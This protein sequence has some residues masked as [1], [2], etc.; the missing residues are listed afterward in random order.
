VSPLNVREEMLD[1]SVMKY[2]IPIVCYLRLA[3]SA[4]R[5]TSKP[6]ILRRVPI[7]KHEDQ[8]P[9]HDS[10]AIPSLALTQ[11]SQARS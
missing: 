5:A 2:N 6:Q 11:S 9:P 3:G 4:A 8:L 1:G 7:V 10:I